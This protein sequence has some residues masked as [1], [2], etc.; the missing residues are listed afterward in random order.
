MRPVKLVMSAFGPYAD[1]QEVDF[2][3]ATDA[4]LFG[5]YG[6]TGSGK[7]SIFSAMTFALFGEAAKREQPISS[8]RSAHAAADLLTEVSF[9]FELG[10]K[11]YL[12]RRQPD[13]SR[14]KAR[15]DGETGQAHAAWLFD[16]TGIDV[17]AINLEGCGTVLAEK[18]VGLV[19]EQVRRLLGYG[20]EQFRQ[21][22]LL[23]QGRFEKFLTSD[24]SERL[25]ILRELFDVTLYRSITE[26]LKEKA[27]AAK[28]KVTEGYSVHGQRLQAEGFASSDELDIGIGAVGQDLLALAAASEQAELTAVAA[29]RASTSA[30][31]LDQRFLEAEQAER[32]LTLIVSRRDEIDRIRTRRDNALKAQRAID[33]Y[34]A[35]DVADAKVSRATVTASEARESLERA[36][37]LLEQAEE[38]LRRE[39]G[40]EDDVTALLR[41]SDEFSRFKLA[42]VAAHD[43][44]DE[45]EKAA[46]ERASLETAAS[47]A[48]TSR[49]DLEKAREAALAS[50]I[51]AQRD[52]V[53]RA[54]LTNELA[55]VQT[56]LTDARKHEK[57]VFDVSGAREALDKAQE[58]LTAETATEEKAKQR[59]E[60]AEQ[61]YLGGQASLLAARLIEGEPCPVCGGQ[62]HPSPAT[63]NEDTKDFEA[64]W[65]SARS[66]AVD[67]SERLQGEREK[68]AAAKGLLAERQTALEKL[69]PPS[70]AVAS[71][72]NT[73]AQLRDALGKLPFAADIA[74]LE[75]LAS[76]AKENAAAA[77]AASANAETELQASLTREAV[78]TRS[79]TDQIAEVPEQF[80][81]ETAVDAAL[82]EVER[83]IEQRKAA[84][85]AAAD[86]FQEASEGKARAEEAVQNSNSRRT[87]AAREAAEARNDYAARLREI[88][89]EHDNFVAYSADISEIETLAALVEDHELA[90]R[91]ARGAAAQASTAIK[92]KQRPDLAGA[93]EQSRSA[94]QSA[95]DAKHALAVLRAKEAHLTRLRDELSNEID[96]LRKLEEETGPLRALADAF[97]GQNEMNTQL[98]SF[99]I[100]AMFDR[101][102]QA[103][104]LRLE[105]M[106][107]GRYRLER[108]IEST[109]GRTKRGLDIRVHD[110]E[111][112]RPRDLST[113]SGGETFIAA[114]SLALG[115]S[116]I[117]EASH[118][119]IRLDTIFIDEGFGSLDTENDTG[120]LDR[121]LQVLQDIVGAS[122]A[123]GLISHVPLV[124]QAVPNGFS[125]I[126]GVGGSSIERR[127]A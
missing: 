59:Y 105:P 61:R 90:E 99:A 32:D 86:Q 96:R 7:S 120:T 100:G 98:E 122:R 60:A 82:T 13:Q 40:R 33:V 37:H 36:V 72:E 21:I 125:I 24:S 1:T 15:G 51:A 84:L 91:T 97:N 74:Q 58:N 113:L 46:R 70:E 80:R 14:P 108:D 71:L 27:I 9:V 29:E 19:A 93:R 89:I 118:G 73:V 30:E 22:V 67:A 76:A 49:D 31:E 54:Q 107:S 92:D 115:L 79:Y 117:V 34:R 62:D 101:V 55:S 28:R 106:T 43:L 116:D 16:V 5:I 126:K 44:K 83:A 85:S 63:S 4:G 20:A 56:L 77:V 57:A 68:V 42:L 112:G 114:L 11:R 104:N 48:K 45:S 64:E 50:V 103:A 102:L 124:Q 69:E 35:I 94:R 88:G 111:T 17:N 6:P 66:D 78:A 2:R 38:S 87:E 18:K 109:G 121:V 127:A 123:V 12:V 23:P 65:K 26:R 119:A 75:K 52:Q 8:L 25:K 53:E 110:V 10:S 39:R 81:D 47:S 95:D 3:E 41:K